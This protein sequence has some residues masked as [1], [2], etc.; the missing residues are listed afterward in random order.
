MPV[1]ILKLT[2]G[3]TILCDILDATDKVVT[4]INP[5]QIKTEPSSSGT[6]MNMV[7][8]QWLPMM[9]EENIMY[10]HQ[11]HIVGMAHAN[12]DM[13]EYYV[14]ALEKILFPERSYEKELRE[15][16]EFYEKIKQ[17]AKQANTKSETV[18]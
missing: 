4:I 3:E 17:I 8:Y 13:Q 12:E 6:R 16:Q 7:A 5:L 10:I 15:R 14:D 2:N 1:Q 11:A 9:E 18:H